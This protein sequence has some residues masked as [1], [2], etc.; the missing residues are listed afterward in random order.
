MKV[1]KEGLLEYETAREFLAE[2][3]KEFGGEDEKEV[4]VAEL[5]RLEQE[6]KIMKE[7]I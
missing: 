1:L 7:F 5:K 6:S 4:K 3:K 2:I